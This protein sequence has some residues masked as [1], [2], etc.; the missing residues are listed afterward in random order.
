M[1]G[2][3]DEHRIDP[4]R[5]ARLVAALSPPSPEAGTTPTSLYAVLDGARDERLYRAVY[6]SGLEYEC[7]F[8]GEISYELSLAAPYLV[9]LGGGVETR[10]GAGAAFTRWLVEEG[11]GRSF[12]IFAWSRAD[13]ETVRRHCRRL[14]QIKDE[15]G[16]RLFFRYYDPRVLRLYLPTCTAAELREVLGPWG[17]LLAEGEEGQVITYEPGG[18]PLRVAEARLDGGDPHTPGAAAR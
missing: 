3:G 14:L 12:G 16:R 4:A 7:L 1:S 17:R 10:T 18:K 11:W 2:T 6:D 5:V 15:A 13:T 8:A 9:R